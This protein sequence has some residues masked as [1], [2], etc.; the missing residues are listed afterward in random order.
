MKVYIGTDI[1]G[2]AGVTSFEDQAYAT[3]RYYDRAKRLLTLEVN[4][5]VEALL[6]EGATEVLVNDGHGPGAIS[7]EDLHPHA[8]LLHGRPTAPRSRR[9]EY[10]RDYDLTM[11]IGQHAMAGNERATLNH[12]Q[13]SRSITS[14]TLNGRFIGEIAQWSLYAG[15]LGMPM[16]FLSG[17]TEACKEAEELIPG[18]TTAA[19]KIGLG[20]GSAISCSME[21]SH[22]RIREGVVQAMKRYGNGEVKPLVWEKPYVLEKRYFTTDQADG[23]SAG[24]G[25]EKID[26]LTVRYRSDDILDVI[27]R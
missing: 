25:Y 10:I 15:G 3:G 22:R 2:V 17:D 27:Y 20:R 9:D 8:R 7:Y 11:M 5:A 1:E 21:E 4:A 23:A 12:T 19:V 13:S 26:D 14:Y 24:P 16:I 6:A 18:V